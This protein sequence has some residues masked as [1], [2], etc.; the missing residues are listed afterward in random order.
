VEAENV[1]GEV[2]DSVTEIPAVRNW[3]QELRFL[4][5]S[6][7]IAPEHE[8]P[9]PFTKVLK[10]VIELTQVWVGPFNERP[11]PQ[12]VQKGQRHRIWSVVTCPL[13]NS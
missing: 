13:F 7:E 12:G 4:A 11:S 6:G 9:T 2:G 5:R 8:P 10:I 1:D 3:K